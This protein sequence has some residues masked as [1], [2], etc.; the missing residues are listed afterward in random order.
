[1]VVCGCSVLAAAAAADSEV[2]EEVEGKSVCWLGRISRNSSQSSGSCSLESSLNLS[3][4]PSV[5]M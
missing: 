5:L 4:P 2:A 3:L 1:M